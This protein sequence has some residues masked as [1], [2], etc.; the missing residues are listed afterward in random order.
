MSE[1]YSN[2]RFKK[3]GG[4]CVR[5]KVIKRDI[6]QIIIPMIL[7]NI[8]QISANL[9]ITA[10]VGRLLANDISAQGICIRITDTL[11]CFY[12]G[13]AIGATVLIARAYG[14]GR[15]QD[16]RKIAEQ[17][18]LTEMIIVF[19]F[20]V[21][22]YFKAPL[23][24]GFFSKDPQILSLA[25]GYMKTIIFEFPFVVITTVV[26]ASFQGY[27]NTKIPMYIAVLMNVVN[28]VC[29]YCF[30]FGAFGIPGM[31]IKGAATAL[32]TAQTVGAGTGLYLLYKK[33]GGLFRKVPSEHRFFS[34]DKKCIYEI[35]T[36][37]IP[38]ALETVFWQVSAI[39]LSKVILFYGNQAFAAY[40]LGI[41]AEEITEMPAIGFSTAS[42]TLAARAIG[43]Q[44]E[45]L[46]KV[47]FKEQL[48]VGVFI[49]SI[50]SVLLIFLP[51][52]FLTLMTDKPE[53]QAIGVVYVFVMGFIQ[54][55]QNLS[56]IYNGTI[57]AMGYK[58]APMLVAGFGIWIVRIPL[59]MLAAYVL[60]LPLTII[61]IIIAMDQVSRFL[62]SVG[63]YYRIN[64]KRE[65]TMNAV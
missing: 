26:T 41:Q 47:Y 56:R 21:V 22:L 30:I 7:E 59:C 8:L 17:T 46:R 10:M 64:K 53:L 23:F 5:K 12:K 25:E 51:R 19:I 4:F 45:E 58:N 2:T 14:A 11:W 42:T 15:H 27:G 63:L 20:Q 32:L 50:T 60:R 65:Q 9:V 38:A 62:L 43:M 39:I 24:L 52:F 34:F 18:I 1:V 40:Q 61:W 36:T 48:K 55:P 28:I 31:G 3:D 37:G 33:K 16:C 57:R 29:G 35:Y 44:D 13:V 6:Y 49:S 54:I